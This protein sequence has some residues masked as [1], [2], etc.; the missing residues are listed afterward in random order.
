MST[1]FDPANPKDHFPEKTIYSLFSGGGYGNGQTGAAALWQ[2]RLGMISKG[3]LGAIQY[4]RRLTQALRKTGFRGQ[5]DAAYHTSLYK[6][7]LDLEIEMV[8]QWANSS[9]TPVCF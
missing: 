5:S 6:I 9:P 7:F 3:P 2:V 8:D 4:G 1:P